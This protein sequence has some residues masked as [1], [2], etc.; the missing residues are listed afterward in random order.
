M[1]FD[2]KLEV[3]KFYC[4]PSLYNYYYC[5]KIVN[6]LARFILVESYQF[7]TLFQATIQQET[8]YSGY[9]VEVTDKK[10]LERLEKM[11]EGY[12]SPKWPPKPN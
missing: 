11:L 2:T 5:E 12:R 9:Y 4:I 3:G 1:G 10:R 8:K 6:T 7:G